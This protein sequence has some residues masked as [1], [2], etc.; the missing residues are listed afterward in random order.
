M[1]LQSGDQPVDDR[2]RTKGPDCVVNEHRVAIDRLQPRA[3]GVSALFAAFD[4]FTNFHPVESST[5]ELLLPSADHD[6]NRFDSRM[7]GEGLDC[8]AQDGLATEF[9]VLLGQAT[10]HAFAFAGGDDK[11]GNGHGAGV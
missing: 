2:G 7:Y 11:C 3:N 9:S 4:Q 6:P 1:K 8:S 10:T 5:R